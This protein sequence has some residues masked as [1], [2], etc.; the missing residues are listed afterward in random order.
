MGASS[1]P[2]KDRRRFFVHYLK[3]PSFPEAL[4]CLQG[5]NLTSYAFVF[6]P[7]PPHLLN[8]GFSPL[9]IISYTDYVH[10]YHSSSTPTTWNRTQVSTTKAT[11]TM[12]STTKKA[13]LRRPST[14]RWINSNTDN[15]LITRHY[16][17]RVTKK[18]P[19]SNI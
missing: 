13:T 7:P 2:W 8:L 16:H 19:T 9:H 11:S 14:T 15:D 5:T 17:P 6:K 18:N 10:K 12:K 3:G 4:K 1:I